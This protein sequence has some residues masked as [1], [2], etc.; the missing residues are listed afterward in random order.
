MTETG[1]DRITRL[2]TSDTF[3]AKEISDIKK[4]I[5]EIKDDIGELKVSFAKWSTGIIVAITVIQYLIQILT[6]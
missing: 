6:K 3:M 2:E 5:K 4:D 1:S